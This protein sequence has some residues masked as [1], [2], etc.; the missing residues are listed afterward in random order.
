[1]IVLLRAAVV[2]VWVVC[3]QV[4]GVLAGVSNP[5]LMVVVPAAMLVV[6]CLVP[7]VGV[8]ARSYAVAL[9]LSAAWLLGVATWGVI[10]ASILLVTACVALPWIAQSTVATKRQK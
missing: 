3:S 2:A 10:S 4:L 9:T 5:A 6:A 7:L 8:G 1:M